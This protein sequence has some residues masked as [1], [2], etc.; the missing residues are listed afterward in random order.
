MLLVQPQLVRR[1]FL[2]TRQESHGRYCV[3]FF[4]E[5]NWTP[6]YIDDRVPCNLLGKPIYSSFR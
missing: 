5:G 1:L 3:Q 6:V 2:Q 4:K